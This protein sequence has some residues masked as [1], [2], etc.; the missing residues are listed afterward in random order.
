M[1]IADL[2]F[3]VFRLLIYKTL[4]H[5]KRTTENGGCDGI[6]NRTK[7]A[8]SSLLV[9]QNQLSQKNTQCKSVHCKQKVDKTVKWEFR[10][11]YL[12]KIKPKSVIWLTCWTKM[13]LLLTH[14]SYNLAKMLF[15]QQD[16]KLWSG[17]SSLTQLLYQFKA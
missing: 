13:F 5:Y 14:L 8:Q 2:L 6:T 9:A 7:P 16:H 12:C 1:A 17:K 15:G 3:F 11:S 10:F 4:Q